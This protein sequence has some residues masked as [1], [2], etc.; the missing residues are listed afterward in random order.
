M[1]LV[2]TSISSETKNQASP[3]VRIA[4]GRA[5]SL[6][7]GLSIV[8]RTPKTA[9]AASRDPAR[10]TCTPLNAPATTASTSAFVSHEMASRTPSDGERRP[11]FAAVARCF[12]VTPSAYAKASS[13][14]S[15]RPPCTPG[16]AEDGEHCVR[17][18]CPCRQLW[19]VTHAGCARFP[20]RYRR[21]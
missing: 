7:S 1:A 11:S 17:V 18:G 15:A 16:A 3:N 12:R 20:R 13:K 2:I 4:S 19:R 6:R 8:F 9:A 5:T 10:E 14:P 21:L